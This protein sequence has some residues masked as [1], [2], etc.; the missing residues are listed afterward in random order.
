VG[1]YVPLALDSGI[2][3]GMRVH[4]LDLLHEEIADGDLERLFAE[5][6]RRIPTTS[7]PDAILDDFELDDVLRQGAAWVVGRRDGRGGPVARIEN[8]GA[9]PLDDPR[10]IVRGPLRARA[11]RNLGV[12]G[13]GNHFLELHVVDEVLDPVAGALGL[14]EGSLLFLMHSGS[15][16]VGKT[17][18][19][20]FARRSEAHGRAAARLLLQKAAYHIA[21]PG[22]RRHRLDYFLRN[23]FVFLPAGSAEG[24]RYA[25]ALAAGANFGY[26]NRAALGAAVEES[27]AAVFGAATKAGLLTDL[28]HVLAQPEEFDGRLLYVHRHGAS[29]AF[30]PSRMA[31]GSVFAS[32]G[33]PFPVPGSMGAASYI[34]VARETAR[35]TLYSANHG[36]GRTLDKP[37]ARA[38]FDAGTVRDELS[39]HRVKLYQHGADSSLAEQAPGAFKDVT[40]VIDVM[41]RTG[42]ATAAVRTRPLAT[43]KG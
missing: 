40:A 7:P 38:S 14:Q 36:A 21:A 19:M 8:E 12:L 4:K 28:S 42:I 10:A 35:T 24:R 23:G 13:G 1:G 29:R 3:C 31:P 30:P 17:M 9:L 26:A 37:E 32:T 27:V 16:T 2:N 41:E 18:S 6:R 34:C 33:Q 22:S 43:V 5:V 25:Q 11:R 15:G 39:G 20:F